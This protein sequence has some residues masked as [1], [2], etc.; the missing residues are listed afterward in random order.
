MITHADVTVGT[1]I[2]VFFGK[3]IS[4]TNVQSG[5]W[6]RTAR[7]PL[8][9]YRLWQAPA[10]FRR[11]PKLFTCALRSSGPRLVRPRQTRSF[12]PTFISLFWER[13]LCGTIV[14][15]W[16]QLQRAEPPGQSNGQ[17]SQGASV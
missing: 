16:L 1:L 2:T 8:T 11:E 5:C 12:L 17:C 10:L 4:L 14:E 13:L 9:E 3:G 15:E 6:K 7:S